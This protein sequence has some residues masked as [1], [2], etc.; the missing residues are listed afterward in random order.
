MA[1]LYQI[2]VLGNPTDDF[3]AELRSRLEQFLDSFG[4]EIGNQVGWTVNPSALD[5]SQRIA[6]VAMY[7]GAPSR[8]DMHLATLLSKSVPILPIVSDLTKVREEIPDV[9]RRLNCLSAQDAGVERIASA[10]LECIGLLPRQRRVFL[11]YRRDEARETALQL[12]DEL[13]ARLFDV[14]LDTH[15]IGPAEDFQNSLWH[16]LCDSDVLLMLDTPTYFESRWTRAEFG[17]ALAKEISVLSIGWPGTALAPRASTASRMELAERDIDPVSGRLSNDAIEEIC[18]QLERVRSES[19]AV[20]SLNLLSNIRLAAEKIGGTFHG[21]GMHMSALIDLPDGRELTIFPTVGVPTATTLYDAF[22]LCPTDRFAVAF[23]PVGFD[24]RW[25]NHLDWLEEQIP[26]ARWIRSH[27]AS[28][29][30]A[31]WED[32]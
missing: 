5:I 18:A 7:V 32:R 9:I 31:D 13:S 4:L 26:S 6:T 14:F 19:L 23:D 20:R 15:R 3:L 17:R 30:L 21:I 28:W 2:I 16:R 22:E 1:H 24:K 29:C 12:F 10:V 27:E 11:S 8:V 25:L